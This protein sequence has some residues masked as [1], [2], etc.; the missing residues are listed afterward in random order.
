MNRDGLT[1]ELPALQI[2]DLHASYRGDVEILSGVDLT[3]R[4]GSIT[5]V[6]GRNGVGK[7]TLLKSIMGMVPHVSGTI[8]GPSGRI[9][10]GTAA[11][12]RVRAGVSMVPEGRGVLN[13]LTVEE[14]LL[15]GGRLQPAAQLHDRLAA[16]LDRFPEIR[17]RRGQR[18]GLLSGG[19]QQMLVIARA[20]M[21]QPRCLLLDEPTLGLAP[22]IAR[23]VAELSRDLAEEGIGLLIAEQNAQA[24]RWSGSRAVLLYGGNVEDIPD[25]D[26][27]IND[28]MHTSS[29]LFGTA[30]GRAV[31]DES[32]QWNT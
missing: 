29:R 21:G 30:K 12:R 15:L 22:L 25:V 16:M 2:M 17:D 18:A 8:K 28:Q 9:L 1:S 3:I 13:S 27:F 5:T 6:L 26:A 4:Q 31:D 7:S 14:N 11:H 10:S 23:R 19:E 32:I 20:L 24:V